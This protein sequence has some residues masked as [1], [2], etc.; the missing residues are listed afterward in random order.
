MLA[1]CRFDDRRMI[2][3]AFACG[4]S[5]ISFFNRAFR[6]RYSM[7]RP[8]IDFAELPSPELTG[9][10]YRAFPAFSWAVCWFRCW[11]SAG[12]L[13]LCCDRKALN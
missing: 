6:A 12:M 1:S 9:G 10:F 13:A 5:D 2:D 11:I 8:G 4:F 3:I 7:L